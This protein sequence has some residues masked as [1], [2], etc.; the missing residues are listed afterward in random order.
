MSMNL[1]T[2]ETALLAAIAD[3]LSARDGITTKSGMIDHE[4]Y[5]SEIYSYAKPMRRYQFAR[6]AVPALC[7]SLQDKGV[8]KLSE[9]PDGELISITA[10][11]S[12]CLTF[13]QETQPIRSNHLWLQKQ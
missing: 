5:T 11:G 1:T 12:E 6:S 10:A 13:W 7:R 9:S 8:V 4:T 2:K 3:T